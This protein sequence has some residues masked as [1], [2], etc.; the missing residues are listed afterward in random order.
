[1]AL[2]PALRHYYE[3]QFSMLATQ[4]WKDMC[5]DLESVLVALKD[6]TTATPENLLNRQGR[7]AE[8]SLILNRRTILS[9]AYEELTNDS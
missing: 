1:M 3:E 4:G 6:V 8:L 2:T 7:I 5:E 9:V